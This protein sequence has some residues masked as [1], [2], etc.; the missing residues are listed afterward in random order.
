MAIEWVRFFQR[1]PTEKGKRVVR[2]DV[3]LVANDFSGD[4]WFTDV[5]FQDGAT[6]TGYVPA[7]REM[8]LRRRDA[9]GNIV[10]KRHYN[11]VLRGQNALVV[12][13][14]GSITTAM[15]ITLWPQ[16]SLPSGSVVMSHGW[17]TRTFTINEPLSPGDEYRFY[18]STRTVAKNGVPTS[19]YSGFYFQCPCGDAKFN[20]DL[21]GKASA[22]ALLEFEEWDRGI[23]GKRL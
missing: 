2:V 5:M 19:K 21:P 20:I 8:H 6:L 9:S 3:K 18:A 16:D 14:R 22:R 12:P 15:D 10:T 1:V 7:A 23:G 11:A 17:R 4:I 13:N